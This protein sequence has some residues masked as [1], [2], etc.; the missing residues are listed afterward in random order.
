MKD[1]AARFLLALQ[2]LTR[3]PTPTDRIYSPSRMATSLR[4]YPLVGVLIGVVSAAV[5][6]FASFAFPHQI[7][8]IIAIAAGLLLTGGF[9]EDGL[10]DTFDGMGGGITREQALTIMKDSRL[11]TYG[12]LALII[13]LGLKFVALAT[14]TLGIAAAALVT[15]HGL[16]R[17]SSVLVIATSRYVRVS[18]AGKP[19]AEGANASSLAIALITGMLIVITWAIVLPIKPLLFGF[20]G[21]VMGHVAMRALFE[22]KLGGYTGDTLGA[23][24]QASEISFYLGIA[25]WV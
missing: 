22:H 20:L 18:G 15:A 12:T 23:V 14:M 10:A 4:Y 11:G 8:V 5:L 3:V 17:L 7:A 19:V 6:S 2:F 16:S 9:H 13:L 1:E 25:A 24:Q 21:I